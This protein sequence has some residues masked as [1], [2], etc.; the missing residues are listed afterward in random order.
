MVG[1]VV[2]TCGGQ[3]VHSQALFVGYVKAQKKWDGKKMCGSLLLTGEP[4]LSNNE[5]VCR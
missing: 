1:Y 2:L 5:K 4:E 3:R